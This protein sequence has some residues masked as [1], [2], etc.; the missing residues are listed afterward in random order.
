MAPVS[1]LPLPPRRRP[2]E[3]GGSRPGRRAVQRR[4]S[5]SVCH[6]P[7]ASPAEPLVGRAVRRDR[8]TGRRAEEADCRGRETRGPHQDR[9]GPRPR[10]GCP[11]QCAQAYRPR[12]CRFFTSRSATEIT[13]CATILHCPTHI[14]QL[15]PSNRRGLRRGQNNRYSGNRAVLADDG[16]VTYEGPAYCYWRV[17][18]YVRANFADNRNAR[19]VGGR[20][21]PMRARRPAA[22]TRSRPARVAAAASPAP[23]DAAAW[24]VRHR[25]PPP[26]TMIVVCQ[27]ACSAGSRPDRSRPR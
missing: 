12:L 22:S 21:L 6:W 17:N 23:A 3:P 26:A 19:Y 4:R 24:R 10:P 16:S 13:R 1:E 20:C 27:T 18:G 15:H 2:V 9:P 11:R 25:A 7:S 8:I 14:R 5:Q